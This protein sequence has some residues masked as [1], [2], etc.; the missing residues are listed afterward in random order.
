MPIEYTDAEIKELLSERKPV[1]KQDLARIVPKPKRDAFSERELWVV[2]ADGNHFVIKVRQNNI[3]PLDFSVILGVKNKRTQQIFRLRRYNG[4]SH[5]HSN[6]LEGERAFYNFHV[7]QA[8][9][10]YQNAEG[11]TEDAYAVPTKEYGDVRSAIACMIK[12]CGIE[13]P[14]DQ[15]ELFSL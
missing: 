14:P 15:P 7:H 13:L 1:R 3:N 8:T 4:K 5:E 6:K 10:R 12:E 9:A 2:G 11:E